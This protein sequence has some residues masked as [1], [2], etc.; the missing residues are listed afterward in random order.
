MGGGWRG[1]AV[2]PGASPQG[3]RR[4]GNSRD[5]SSSWD[6]ITGLH[7]LQGREGRKE[8]KGG[9]ERKEKG[10]GKGREDDHAGSK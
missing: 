4:T 7:E 5:D 6:S 9:K 2:E 10:K 8:G 3:F 1:K